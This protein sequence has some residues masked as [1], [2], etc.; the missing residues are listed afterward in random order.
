MVME[1]LWVWDRDCDGVLLAVWVCDAVCV[2]DWVGVC[3]WDG[4]V[5]WL[6]VCVCEDERVCV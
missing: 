2:G 1:A 6:E 5:D 3:D 4:D